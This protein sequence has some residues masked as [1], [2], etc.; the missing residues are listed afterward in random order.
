MKNENKKSTLEAFK[1][2]DTEDCANEPP[3]ERLRFF[4]SLMC[5]SIYGDKSQYNHKNDRLDVEQ[6]FDDVIE[7]IESLEQKVDSNDNN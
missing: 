4:V 7:Q 2:F 5:D 6:F 3:I 1:E